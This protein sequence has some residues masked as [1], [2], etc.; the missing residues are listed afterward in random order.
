MRS[1]TFELNLEPN[2]RYYLRSLSRFGVLF[3]NAAM[4]QRREHPGTL[5]RTSQMRSIDLLHTLAG[6]DP[7][8]SSVAYQLLLEL[9][10]V[11]FTSARFTERAL[12]HFYPLTWTGEG[13]EVDNGGILLQPDVHLPPPNFKDPSGILSRVRVR[14][15]IDNLTFVNFRW[16]AIPINA[17]PGRALKRAFG[18]ERASDGI[19]GYIESLIP[20]YVITQ[21]P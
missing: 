14:T 15:I 7:L 2:T 19:S 13:I 12:S 11:T 17:G 1:Q 9:D 21:Y 3:Y 5:N 18:Y 6:I 10:V 4:K 8:P 16:R 20:S